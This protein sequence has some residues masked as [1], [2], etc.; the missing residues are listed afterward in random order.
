MNTELLLE[1]E[2]RGILPPE[3]KALLDEARNRGLLGLAQETQQPNA[4]NDAGA[5]KAFAY[6]LSGGQ[7]PFGNRITSALG[8]AGAK[9]YDKTVGDN[10]LDGQSFSDLYGQALADTKATQE[11]NPGAT[12]SGN[13]AGMVTTLPIASSKAI[14]G[15]TPTQGIR[16]AVNSVPQ[17]LSKVG[18]WASSGKAAKDASI[19]TKTGANALRGVKGGA[20]AAPIMGAYSAGEA[21]SGEQWDEFKR[22]AGLGFG[23][24]F[25]SPFAGAA[26][27]KLNE[28]TVVPTADK[29]KSVATKLYTKARSM[30]AEFTD[31]ATNQLR[32]AV[33]SQ[34]PTDDFAKIAIGEDEI[35]AFAKR[36]EGVSGKK[37]SLESFESLDK[38]LGEKATKAAFSGENDLARRYGIIQGELRNIVESPDFI[39]GSSDGV[40]AYR[41]ATDMWRSSAKMRD[42]EQIIERSKT[43]VGGE[44]AGIKA[45]FAR[46][47]RNPKLLRGYTEEEVK[48]I[49]K[50]ARTG[51]TEGLLRTF[52]SRLL[53]IIGGGAGGPKGALAGYALSE[54]SQGG[55][56]ALRG[57]EATKIGKIIAKDTGLI[58]TQKRIP[59]DKLIK[60][61]TDP[62]PPAKN[63]ELINLLQR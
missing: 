59:T 50:A 31:D 19:L 48:A 23:F 40:R 24:G 18:N 60:Y 35:S 7:L 39:K 44:G 33:Q 37:M 10:V 62:T 8:A 17:Y 36:L 52:G 53:P 55:A 15:A 14:V 45:G 22:G 16:G 1:A 56:A 3:K 13:I 54:V 42:I 4:G 34:I 38:W 20:V 28:K 63:T 6:G 26:F 30:G 5:G 61:L 27:S 29:I 12:L 11:A 9:V 57:A 47:V 46:L 21:D 43:Y 41:E 49:E 51:R 32:K 2:K 25:A 58:E